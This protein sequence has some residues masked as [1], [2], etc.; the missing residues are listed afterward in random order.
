MAVVAA[1][2]VLAVAAISVFAFRAALVIRVARALLASV[3]DFRTSVEPLA[4]QIQAD[5]QK[6]AARLA[7]RT[8]KAT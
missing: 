2:L 6:A 7:G 5:A 8:G 4:R 1:V 3:S